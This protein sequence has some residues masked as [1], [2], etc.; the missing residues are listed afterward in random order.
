MIPYGKQT[1]DA[2][3]IEAVVS[4]L[5][6]DYLTT[7]PLVERFEQAFARAV[8]APHAVAVSSGTA[9]LHCA[10][11]ALGIGPGDEVIVPPMTFAAT[12][13]CVVY[14]NGVPIFADV[15]P[16]TLLI[17][18][19][20]VE[21]CIT[22]RTRAVIA[23]DYAGQPC[24]YQ[25]LDEICRRKGIALAADACHSLGAS[26]DARPAGSLADLTAFSFHPVKPITTGEGGMV[27][28]GD[29]A[30]AAALRTIR[31]HGISV[32][33]RQRSEQHS[34]VYEITRTGFNYRLSDIHCALGLSQLAKLEA[35]T[36]RR[37][38]IAARYREAFAASSVEPLALRPGASHSYHLFVVRLPAGMD[39][40]AAFK[41][42]HAAGIGV[43]VHYIPVYLHPLYK[44]LFGYGPGLCPQAEAAYERILS[45]PIFPS[46]TDQ[47][48]E[49][50]ITEV[51]KA[52]EAGA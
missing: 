41:R 20:A 1:L 6:S 36:E 2:D 38:R 39:R 28:T 16:D 46:M 44:K 24:D 15:D 45:L 18:P 13:N 14:Q 21:A 23:V 8:G 50:V 5:R 3:D 12:A 34:W 48:V 52:G 33:H 9:A 25:T 10:V 35:F 30:M 32:D 31:N 42:L 40:T 17:S 19:E 22:A 7:G 47:Q 11:A 43:N 37:T 29:P 26:Q 51:L 27:T 49:T 4:V